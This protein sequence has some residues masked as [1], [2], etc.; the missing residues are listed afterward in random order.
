MTFDEIED[1][2]GRRLPMRMTLVPT[3]EPDQRTVV[4]Y[5]QLELDIPVDAELFTRRGL[6]RIAR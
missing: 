4:R 3:D 2:S 6:R 5:E 1:V